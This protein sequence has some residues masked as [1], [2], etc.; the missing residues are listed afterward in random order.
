MALTLII[1]LS[2]ATIYGKIS[3]IKA[4]NL[5]LFPAFLRRMGQG[6]EN[7]LGKIVQPNFINLNGGENKNEKEFIESSDVFKHVFCSF[8]AV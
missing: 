5:Q 3:I 2:C 7:S 1:N 4:K 6:E 8:I